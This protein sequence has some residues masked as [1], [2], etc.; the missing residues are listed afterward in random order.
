MTAHG[1]D[2][3][4]AP[5][6]T[7]PL[8]AVVR[9]PGSKSLTNRYLVLAALADSGSR[10]RAP[11]RS[12]DSLLMAEGLRT[13]GADIVDLADGDGDWQVT[14]GAVRGGGQLDCGLAG[15]VMRFLPPV[16]ALA[17]GPVRFDGDEGARLRPMGPILDALRALG[18]GVDGA[19]SALPFT[20]Q[21][22]GV[23]GV[24]GGAVTLDA[25]QSS[26]F[27]SALLLA[28][29]RYERGV[30][31]HHDGK[32]VPSQPHIEMTV[33]TLRAAG[34]VVDDTEAN[35][36]RVEPGPI[37]GLDVVVE[38]DLSNAGPFLAA[39]LVAGGT[40][41]VPDWPRQTT[42]AGDLLREI[43]GAMGAHVEWSRSGLR[44]TSD[45]VVQGIDVDLHEA[46]ELTPTVAALAAL[47][48][49]P[50]WIRGVAHIRGHE[51]D[52]LAA[53][54]TELSAMGADVVQTDDGLRIQPA[55]LQGR[56]FHTYHD[57][58]M[59]T[60]GAILGL[61]VP[62][63]IVEN[64][65]TTAKTLPDFTGRWAALLAGRLDR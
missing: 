38:P 34:V 10:L 31:V 36:W 51:T 53:L 32:P 46:S 13:L 65:D 18:V 37:N 22:C 5:L 54:D 56:L 27:V 6:A 7:G 16:A 48:V 47:A 45:G 24:P 12:R 42:Q 28:G 39:A 15:T 50:S 55:P 49:S 52:R 58:R 29:A 63:V 23:Q 4:P 59:A 2:H 25:S 62:D 17:D 43:L 64:V 1:A 44:V 8:D 3:W 40:V 41:L 11:L 14:P 35:T 26:Q 9:L 33:A 61:R 60:A 19:T 21:G 30:T 57:H 20:V